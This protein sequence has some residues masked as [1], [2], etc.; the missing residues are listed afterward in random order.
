MTMY[1]IIDKSTN[2]YIKP[3]ISV[4]NVCDEPLLAASPLNVDDGST[5][6]PGSADAPELGFEE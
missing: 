4:N 5:A 6:D 2:I 1:N 3:E